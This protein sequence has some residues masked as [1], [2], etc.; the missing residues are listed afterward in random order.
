MKEKVK[1]EDSIKNQLKA[2]KLKQENEQLRQFIQKIPPQ[3]RREF[4]EWRE[5]QEQNKEQK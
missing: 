4:A 3:V 5:A 2:A 1:G